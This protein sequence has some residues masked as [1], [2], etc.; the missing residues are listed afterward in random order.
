METNK[1]DNTKKKLLEALEEHKG[2]I[3]I[4]CK[5]IGINR[6]S[7]Y[8]WIAKDEEFKKAV[9]EIQDVAID[10]VE[11]KLFQ[12]IDEGNPTSTIFYLK[13]KAKQRG[14]VERQEIVH[15]GKLE[16]TVVE[17]R[18]HKDNDGDNG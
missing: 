3:S 11:S 2:I 4:A 6:S 9:D 1:T 18:V 5:A 10:F 12:Q 13:T 15:D 17:W 16:N 14:Y 7:Y 8:D